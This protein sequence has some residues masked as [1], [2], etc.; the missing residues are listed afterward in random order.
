[1]GI[2][3]KGSFVSQRQ[4]PALATIAAAIEGETL[5]LSSP[6]CADPC[7]VPL[8]ESK[9]S[10]TT[11]VIWRDECQVVDAGD[12]A[13]AWLSRAMRASKPVRLVRMAPGTRRPQSQPQALGEDTHTHFADAS[14]LLVINRASL[15][16]LNERLAEGSKPV[17]SMDRFRPNVVI[18]GLDAFAEQRV[19]EL[20]ETQGR[21]SLKLCYPCERCAVITVEQRTGVMD[22]E[23]REP[24]RTLVDLNPMPGNPKAPAFGMNAIVSSGIGENI[25]VGDSLRAVFE[26]E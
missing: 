12:E 22:R 7:R 19:S 16:R 10:P 24:F 20:V 3:D 21:Y 23:T 1:M 17:V 13:S 6:E 14:P 11:A 8:A 25:E 15:Q 18:E 2:N 4:H 5:V 9:S 26:P